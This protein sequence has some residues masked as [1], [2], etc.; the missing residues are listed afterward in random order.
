MDKRYD[1]KQGETVKCEHYYSGGV[2]TFLQVNGIHTSKSDIE[3]ITQSTKFRNK[4]Y[5]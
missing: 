1:I 3:D 2:V 4:R 5:E